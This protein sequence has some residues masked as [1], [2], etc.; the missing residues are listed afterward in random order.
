VKITKILPYLRSYLFF[1]AKRIGFYANLGH[2]DLGDEASFLAVKKLLNND[3]L[4]ISKKCY[5]FNPGIL[6]AFLIGSGAVLRWESPYIPKRLL[7]RKKWNFLVVLFSAGMNCDYNKEFSEEIKSRI[8][9]LCGICD[10]LS[11]R[12]AVSQRFLNGLGFDDVN[13]LP[14]PELALEEKPYKPAFNKKGFTVGI[15]LSPHSEFSKEDFDKI[16]NV[17][18]QFTDYLTASNKDVI[19]L[20]F[21]TKSSEDTKED[22]LIKEIMKKV[23]DKNMVKDFKEDIGPEEMLSVIKN[24]CDI[25]VCMRLHAAVFS[26][27]AGVPFLC[28]TYN[29]MHDGFLDMLDSKDLGLAMTD[30][31]VESLK[32]KYEYVLNN[33]K[34]LKA[35]II[36]RRDHLKNMIY[37]EVEKIKNLEGMHV[38]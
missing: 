38:K 30:L 36:A 20:R 5:A 34:P 24:Y 9:K 37:N 26:A 7:T 8:K 35:R 32:A 11:V 13:I 16:V 21:E 22:Y 31:S 27:N 33:Y 2:G 15:A 3:I 19:Y 14:D 1:G 10:Y 4:P 17:F 12:D 18:S 6:K 28:V 25:M 29:F 23:K